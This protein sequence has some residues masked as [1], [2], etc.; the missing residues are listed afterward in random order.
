[1]YK[2][3]GKI[4]KHDSLFHDGGNVNVLEA[5]TCR[6]LLIVNLGLNLTVNVFSAI[7]GIVLTA[8]IS[9]A[10]TEGPNSRPAI[11]YADENASVMRV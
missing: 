8:T 10:W 3:S 1:M 7:I 9:Y 4:Q 2:T 6:M 5:K 11:W